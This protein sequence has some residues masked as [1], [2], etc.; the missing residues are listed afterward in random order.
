MI[1]YQ[2]LNLK[3]ERLMNRLS[4]KEDSGMKQRMQDP[5]PNPKP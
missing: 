3:V 5:D 2:N 4:G 1:D